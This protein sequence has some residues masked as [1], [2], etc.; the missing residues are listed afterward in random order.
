MR[1]AS[2]DEARAVNAVIARNYDALVEAQPAE[3][4]GAIDPGPVLGLA[5][6]CGC[7][8][9]AATIDACERARMRCAKFGDRAR[10]QIW[11]AVRTR[12][13]TSGPA[14][15]L[16][17]AAAALEQDLMQLWHGRLMT[18]VWVPDLSR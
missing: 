2:V 8:G 4:A 7:A 16:E 14:I 18:P 12:I 17:S 6:L 13:A 3:T 10:I 5:A 1:E 15:S 11:D 9:D